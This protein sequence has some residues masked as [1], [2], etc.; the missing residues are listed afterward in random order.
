VATHQAPHVGDVLPLERRGHHARWWLGQPLGEQ[1][2]DVVDAAVRR[3][4]TVVIALAQR[5][6]AA[7]GLLQHRL[8]QRVSVVR[9]QQPQRG[10]GL[11]RQVQQRLVQLALDELGRPPTGPDRL[12]DASH[13]PVPAAALVDERPPRG[14]DPSR[15]GAELS[16]VDV[17][18]AWRVGADRGLQ[19]HQPGQR[20]GDEHRL[21]QRDRVEH[22]RHGAGEEV[23]VSAV[24]EGL[25]LVSGVRL[26]RRAARSA[27]VEGGR[28]PP[29]RRGR[30]RALLR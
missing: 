26:A 13:R 11:D 23:V 28:G 22:E 21:P 17:L 24:D 14:D 12:T 30:R 27:A 6:M 2:V 9:A 3:A 1:P 7:C 16:H 5:G 4:A 18:H 25:V 8:G 29:R 19:L 10:V 15:V 20:D